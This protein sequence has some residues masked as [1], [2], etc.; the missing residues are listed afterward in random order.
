M[1]KVSQISG[2]IGYSGA[3]KVLNEKGQTKFAIAALKDFNNEINNDN[4][5]HGEPGKKPSKSTTEQIENSKYSNKTLT[6]FTH[7]DFTDYYLKEKKSLEGVIDAIDNIS[8]LGGGKGVIEIIKDV[9]KGNLKYS[10][11]NIAMIDIVATNQDLKNRLEKLNYVKDTYDSLHKQNP[12]SS[13]GVYMTF[14]RA[15]IPISG[16]TGVQIYKFVDIYTGQS[17]GD[18]N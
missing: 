10:W 18:V 7:S 9:F 17:I 11:T 2:A 1:R 4:S 13:Y 12:N 8:I 3:T 15:N 5:E 14:I 6:T 16:G